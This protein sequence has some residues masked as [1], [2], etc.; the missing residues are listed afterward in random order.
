VAGSAGLGSEVAAG[1]GSEVAA[2]WGSEVAAGWGS[3]VVEGWGSEV[4]AGWGL[5]AVAHTLE[6]SSISWKGSL[7][8]QVFHQIEKLLTRFQRTD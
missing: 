1:W 3:E 2:G 6:R 7:A 5:E 4:A 8:C